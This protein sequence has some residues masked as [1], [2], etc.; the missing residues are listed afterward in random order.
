MP[1]PTPYKIVVPLFDDEDNLV[2]LLNSLIDVGVD[3]SDIIISM[4]GPRGNIVE[5]AKKYDFHMVYSNRKLTPSEA[6]N[7]GAKEAN[8][9]Y[10]VFL[11]SDIFVTKIWK[12]ALDETTVSHNIKLVGE[13]Y[14]ISRSPHWIEKNWFE[15]IRKLKRTYL[16]GGNI[17]VKSEAFYSLKGFDENLETGEDFDFCVRAKI[18]GITPSFD[19]RLLVHHEGN[20]KSIS[21]FIKREMWHAKGDLSSFSAFFKSNVMIAS[22]IYILIIFLAIILLAFGIYKLTILFILISLGLA[23]VLTLYKL[24]G[25]G[26]NFLKSTVIMNFYLLGRGV[27]LTESLLSRL[28][29]A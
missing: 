3:T 15:H 19:E 17:I 29:K 13:T 21:Q 18:K 28:W 23:F 10:F 24:K 11:D 6:R 27:A 22:A 16:N 7:I 4:S 12:E 14:D 1:K 5:L 8:A 26:A 25:T 20:P 2:N 9:E